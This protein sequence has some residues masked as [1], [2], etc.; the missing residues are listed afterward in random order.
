MPAGTNFMI[1]EGMLGAGIHNVTIMEER[2]NDYYWFEL[3]NQFLHGVHPVGF[4]RKLTLWV[5][6]EEIPRDRC[7]FVLRDQWIRADHV[8]SIE[9]IFWYLAEPA[10]IYVQKDGGLEK[11]EHEIA[12]KVTASRLDQSALLDSR[13]IWPMREQTVCAKMLLEED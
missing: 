11:G 1:E 8:G 3:R 9:D 4:M 12:L 7:F 5:D 6:G 10:R 2:P 13:E